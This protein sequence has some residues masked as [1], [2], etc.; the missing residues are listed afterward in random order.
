[1]HDQEVAKKK[2]LEEAEYDQKE[3]GKPLA[4]EAYEK[5]VKKPKKGI[6]ARAEEKLKNEE[7]EMELESEVAESQ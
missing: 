3:F 5:E 4:V 6:L 1:M 7:S 2:A